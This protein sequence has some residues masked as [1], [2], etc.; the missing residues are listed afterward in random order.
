M[1][2]RAGRG[3]AWLRE[4]NSATHYSATADVPCTGC[5][6][7]L[8]TLPA[9][10]WTFGTGAHNT[11][12]G[13]VEHGYNLWDTLASA[14][15]IGKHSGNGDQDDRCN[16]CHVYPANP[17]A[18]NGGAKIGWVGNAANNSTYH[19]NSSIEMNSTL[20]YTTAAG[21]NQYGCT[22]NCHQSGLIKMEGCGWAVN[23]IAGPAACTGCHGNGATGGT[24][25]TACRRRAAATGRCT[26]TARGC[27]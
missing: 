8:A 17:Y 12:D 20:G 27:T 1:P 13:S 6:G 23:L 24:G 10:D 2:R 7:G 21:A 22:G 11:T 25:R 16:T 5:H 14:D 4:W 9:N 26:R 19:G 3:G 15:V 18:K